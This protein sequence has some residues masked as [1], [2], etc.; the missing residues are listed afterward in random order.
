MIP[1]CQQTQTDF[2]RNQHHKLNQKLN[3]R[4]GYSGVYFNRDYESFFA[5]LSELE[6]KKILKKFKSIYVQILFNYFSDEEN[7]NELIDRLVESAFF[8]NLPINK[9][10]E[11]HMEVIDDLERQL[12]FESLNI[13]Y[14]ADYRLALID[15]IAHLGEMYRSVVCKN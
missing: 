10:V 2:N 5:N 13:D 15:V 3:E 1:D 4:L 11:I 7:V 14:L 12:K 9:V 6:Q 8:V